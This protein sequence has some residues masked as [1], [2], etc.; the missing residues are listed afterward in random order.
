MDIASLW[1]HT[2]KQFVF[3]KLLLL[4][5][6]SFLGKTCYGMKKILFYQLLMPHNFSNYRAVSE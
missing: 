1:K 2:A 3:L 5:A 6:E 4:S